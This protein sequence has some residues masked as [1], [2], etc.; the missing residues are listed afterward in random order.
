MSISARRIDNFAGGLRTLRK[1][2]HI[3]VIKISEEPVQ[4]AARAGRSEC[5]TIGASSHRETFGH[6]LAIRREHR[7]ELAQ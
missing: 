6:S 5:L 3:V 2:P 1:K 4:L 7:I